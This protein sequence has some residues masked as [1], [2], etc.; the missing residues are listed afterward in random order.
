MAT[1]RDI[2]EAK[3]RQALLDAVGEILK[4]GSFAKL[5]I[6]IISERAKVDKAFVYRKYGDFSGLLDEY[7]NKKDFWYRAFEELKDLNIEDHKSFMKQI[8]RSQFENIY[9]NEELQQFLVWELGDKEGVTSKVAVTREILAEKMLQQTRLVLDDI[10]LNLNNVYALFIA[11]IYYLILH[12]EKSTFCN[13][14]ITNKQGRA[15]LLETIDLLVDIIFKENERILEMEQAILRAK[16]LGLP[17]EDIAYV[18]G[19]PSHLIVA[20]INKAERNED[21]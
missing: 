19:L 18:L 6:N 10:N 21:V 5:G 15:Q 9:K 20:C 17:T 14:D 7:L 4:E 2:K 8:L 13:L 12:R 16:K 11:G 3:Y 1:A